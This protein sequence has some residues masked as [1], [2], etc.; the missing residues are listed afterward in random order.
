MNLIKVT[1]S[2]GESHEIEESQLAQFAKLGFVKE[3][4]KV[5]KEK[6]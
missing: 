6:K 5:V 2:K 3:G 1:N 4:E